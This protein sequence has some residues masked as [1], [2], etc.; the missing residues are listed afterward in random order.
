[1]DMLRRAVQPECLA[2]YCVAL[3]HVDSKVC[4]HIGKSAACK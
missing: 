3:Q 4:M 2:G 1:M